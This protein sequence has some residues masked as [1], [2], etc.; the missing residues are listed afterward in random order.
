MQTNSGI[1]CKVSLNDQ[2]RRFL[3]TGTEFASLYT[4]VQQVLAVDGEF[5]L[6]YIDNEGD[7]VTVSSDEEL[8]Y[9][10]GIANN[11]LRL[12]VELPNANATETPFDSWRGGRGGG[13]CRRGGFGR[14]GYGARHGHPYTFEGRQQHWEEKK[15]KLIQKRDLFKSLID[16]FPTSRELNAEE[17]ARLN[18]LQAKYRRLDSH[19]KKCEGWEKKGSEK[20]EKKWD[21]RER[22]LEKKLSKNKNTPMLS[23]AAMEEIKVL[24]VQ[25][26]S[27]KPALKEK[28]G[29]IKAKKQFLAERQD[30]ESTERIKA[31]IQAVKF[32]I[33]E[34]KKQI[35]PLKQRFSELKAAS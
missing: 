32:E 22:K 9:A 27:L 25:I 8:G 4:Q 18:V 1:H 30:Q 21:K 2:F 14:Q 19:L 13:K 3:F 26:K 15:A 20:C 7:L 31:E 24:K 35:I 16:E 12:Q 11:I 34:L 28:K 5:V 33:A 6:K 29:L 17:Q 10:L 23:P